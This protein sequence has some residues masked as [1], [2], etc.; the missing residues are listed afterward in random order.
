M[1]ISPN[2]DGRQD[3]IT[4]TNTVTNSQNPEDITAVKRYVLIIATT[5]GQAVRTFAKNTQLPPVIFFDGK[6]ASGNWLADGDYTATLE[7]TTTD[8]V[9]VRTLPITIHARSNLSD[10]AVITSPKNGFVTTRGVIN[11]QGQAPKP[12]TDDSHSSSSMRGKVYVDICVDT[13]FS[14]NSVSCDVSQSVEVDENGF[15]STIVILPTVAGQE[16]T[17]HFITA[18]ARDDYGNQTDKSNEVHVIVDTLDPFASAEIIPTFQGLNTPEEIQKFLNGEINIYEL[19]SLQIRAHV[20]ENTEV[21]DLDLADYTELGELP[22][23]EQNSGTAGTF[24]PKQRITTINNK[25]EENGTL[26][27]YNESHIKADHSPTPA[28]DIDPVEACTHTECLWAVNYPIP[29]GL[30]GGTYEVRFRGYK[31]ETVQDITRGF[32]LDGRITSAPRI[33]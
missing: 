6:D 31:G 12:S 25:Q 9:I 20:T 17:D 18:R 27:P 2:G 19:R 32:V 33:Y 8:G 13:I 30:S 1:Y 3:G 24:I 26:N 11:V 7:I 15:F 21:V 16:K 14:P 28:K 23:S 10:E 29:S 22:G 4:F 5:S